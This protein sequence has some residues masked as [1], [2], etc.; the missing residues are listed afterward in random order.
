MVCSRKAV[1]TREFQALCG[2]YFSFDGFQKRMFIA[3]L[4]LCVDRR[5]QGEAARGKP[6]ACS[7]SSP[8]K[9]EPWSKRRRPIWRNHIAIHKGDLVTARLL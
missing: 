5:M 3:G 2:D 8:V 4:H 1:L 9:F 6:C 7:R